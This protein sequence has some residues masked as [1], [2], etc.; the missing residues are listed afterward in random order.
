MN[1]LKPR[2]ELIVMGFIASLFTTASANK[3]EPPVI[4]NL[5]QN[6][7]LVIDVR[8]AGEFSGGYFEGAINIPHTHITEKIGNHETDKS[9]WIIVYCHSGIRSA[10]A[11]K[12][13]EKA[14]Y[15]RVVNGGSL[16]QMQA[17]P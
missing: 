12:A 5:I 2:R 9:R 1:V 17:L 14:G 4:P 8:S 11:K 6:G 16:K 10:A 13:L 15:S 7:A 3:E